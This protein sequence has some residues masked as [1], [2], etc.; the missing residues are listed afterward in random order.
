LHGAETKHKGFR[1]QTP[2]CPKENLCKLEIT[3]YP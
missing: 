2:T 1:T 3:L